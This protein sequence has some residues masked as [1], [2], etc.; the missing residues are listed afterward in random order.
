[1]PLSESCTAFNHGPALR[2]LLAVASGEVEGGFGVRK[3]ASVLTECGLLIRWV[4]FDPGP[5]HQGWLGFDFS[6]DD[7]SGNRLIDV[8]F[9]RDRSYL[10]ISRGDDLRELLEQTSSG[11]VAWSNSDDR[12]LTIR[13]ERKDDIYLLQFSSLNHAVHCTVKGEW[14]AF[15]RSLGLE[16]D[17]LQ[18]SLR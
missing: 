11:T 8:K 17:T 14:V 1:M 7:A 6:I 4:L 3:V 9:S 13:G 12:D 5:M 10:S 16:R 2:R 15:V 18:A